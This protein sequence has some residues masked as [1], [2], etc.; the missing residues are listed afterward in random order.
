MQLSSVFLYRPSPALL[1]FLLIFSTLW[2]AGGASHAD[3]MGQAVTRGAAWLVLVMAILWRVR[4]DISRVRTPF[5]ILMAA[6]LLALLQLV[7]L[8]ASLWAALPGRDMLA[9]P[10]LGDG[11]W[12]PLSLTPS[13]TWLS[14]S[15]LIVP[16]VILL[17]ISALRGGERASLPTLLLGMIFL[18]T[19]VGLL[20][21]SG[22]ALYNPLINDSIGGVSGMFANRNH[23]ALFLAIGCV[24]TPLWCFSDEQQSKWRLPAALAL[25]TL[26]AL[27]ILATGSRAGIALGALAL[28]LGMALAW[29]HLRRAMRKAPRW[30]FPALIAAAITI[31]AS[32]ILISIAADRADALQRVVELDASQDMRARA[33]PTIVSMIVAYFPAG[34]GFG[35]F[36]PIFRVHEPFALLK[37][38]YFNHAHNDFLEIILDGGLPALLLLIAAVGLTLKASVHAWRGHGPAQALPKLGSAILLL[39]FA[40]SAF[41]YPARTP[42]MMAV[43]AIAAFWLFHNAKPRLEA[44]F[45]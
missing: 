33:L 15:S 29:P 25:M 18:S 19:L 30:A 3:V 6:L 42:M 20:Q 35:G 22:V 11:S 10:L 14:A 13:A 12:R 34:S 36:D 2:V 4:P 28:S 31:I 7:P 23:F 44:D 21:F 26:F 45:T 41:D 16:L 27:S 1:L 38:T 8:P 5:C 9:S 43:I 39:I 37:P 17:L 40:A 24:I 32:F